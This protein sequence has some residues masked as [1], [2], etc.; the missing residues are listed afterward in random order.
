[1]IGL[2]APDPLELRVLQHPQQLDLGRRR[3]L[4]DLVEEERA[5]VGQLE[6][7]ELALAGAR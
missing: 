3:Q 5:P 4:A 6:P 2:L 1:M 7:A